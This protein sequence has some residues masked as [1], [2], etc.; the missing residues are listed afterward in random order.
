MNR[1]DVRLGASIQ[2][3]ELVGLNGKTGNANGTDIVP[4]IHIRIHEN[5][6]GIWELTDPRKYLNSKFDN[7]GNK[8]PNTGNCKQ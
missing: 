7:N 3:G 8:D 5:N 1:I 2:Q 4:H 6:N